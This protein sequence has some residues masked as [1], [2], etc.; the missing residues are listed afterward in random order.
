MFISKTVLL[1]FLNMH[2][3]YLLFFIYV[4]TNTNNLSKSFR[5]TP[6]K[7]YELFFYAHLSVNLSLSRINLGLLYR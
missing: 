5:F 4:V 3:S 1:S 6:I 7:K 2:T